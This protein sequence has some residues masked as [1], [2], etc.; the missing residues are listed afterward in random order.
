[1]M[2]GWTEILFWLYLTN[3]IFIIIHEMDSAYWKEWE[4][5]GK[6]SKLNISGFLILHFPLLIISF[7]G[8]INIYKVNNSGLLIS[9]LLALAGL[10]AFFF[11]A[12]Y[13]RH[14]RIR[15]NNIT[16]KSILTII[17]ILSLIQLP[18]TIYMIL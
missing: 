8:A 15:F 4:M 5:M 12:Y 3:L 9:I 2:T 7:I 18:L 10:F 1:M 6:L 16:S 13:L 17:L 14:D 11:H